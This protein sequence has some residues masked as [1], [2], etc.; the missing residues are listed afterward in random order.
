M[1]FELRI[2]DW[3]SQSVIQNPRTNPQP[4]PFPNR[5]ETRHG[6][7]SQGALVDSVGKSF[8]EEKQN[9]QNEHRDFEAGCDEGHGFGVK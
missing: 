7:E 1:G 4:N 8:K 3:E 6:S 9:T 5:A 2:L